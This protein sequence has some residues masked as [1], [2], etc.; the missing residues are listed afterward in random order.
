MIIRFNTTN[1]KSK[2][3]YQVALIDQEDN[4][5]PITIHKQFY[6]NNLIYKNIIYSA[7][8]EPIETNFTLR[9]ENFNY[10]RYYT[11]IV[12]G[13]D[14]YGNNYN[15]FYMEPKT[16]FI[17]SPDNANKNESTNKFTNESGDISNTDIITVESG[18]AS[19]IDE[20]TDK[21]DESDKPI[22]VNYFPKKKDNERKKNA[23]IIVL[24]IL[25][26]II[27]GLL[28]IAIAFYFKKNNNITADNSSSELNLKIK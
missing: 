9:Q 20:E 13:K 8:I 11:I 24:S 15:Y 17:S 5:D 28:T 4:I 7:G 26:C 19:A 3:E 21:H 22:N 10:N 16:L 23:I 14:I 1:Y 25:G 18:I 12:Y 2:L 6:E 27:V